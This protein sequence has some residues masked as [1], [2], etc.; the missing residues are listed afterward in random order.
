MLAENVYQMINWPTTPLLHPPFP[1][2]SPFAL[3]TLAHI[4]QIMDLEVNPKME[5]VAFFLTFLTDK[6]MTLLLSI[7]CVIQE[8]I[9][10]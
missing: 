1:V 6:K 8:I 4:F 9:E 3:F 2:A 7:D 10:T 5:K